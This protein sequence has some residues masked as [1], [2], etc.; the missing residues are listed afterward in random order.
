MKFQVSSFKF[1]VSGFKFQVFAR[2]VRLSEVEALYVVSFSR[3]LGTL[4]VTLKMFSFKFQVNQQSTINN[5]PLTINHSPFT[6]K[7]YLTPFH[8]CLNSWF[9]FF[10]STASPIIGVIK[11]I[12]F[13]D[14]LF[15]S[16][17]LIK[18]SSQE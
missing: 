2:I 1:Q 16:V 6:I 11:E 3:I 7:N 18:G 8:H 17:T 4:T 5:Q 13:S 15:N 14:K 10:N 9:S 12:G